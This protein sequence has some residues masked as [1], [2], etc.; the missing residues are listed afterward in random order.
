MPGLRFAEE[1]PTLHYAPSL[2]SRALQELRIAYDA[3]DA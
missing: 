2:A 1:E 3:P